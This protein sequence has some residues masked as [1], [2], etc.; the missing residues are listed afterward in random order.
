VKAL[1][2]LINAV[3]S[4]MEP[5]KVLDDA[6]Q[7]PYAVCIA[8]LE[9]S[10]GKKKENFTQ[11]ELDK[12]DQCVKDVQKESIGES[13]DRPQKWDK[14]SDGDRHKLLWPAFGDKVSPNTLIM[15]SKMKFDKLPTDIKNFI[16]TVKSFPL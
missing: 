5:D 6:I 1:E 2:H 9:K 10:T 16:I 8:S 4:G 13:N 3:E 15:I 14:M 7:S 11:D 12:L